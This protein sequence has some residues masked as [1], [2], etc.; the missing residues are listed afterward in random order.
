MN[1]LISF[2]SILLFTVS[3]S[4]ALSIDFV[5]Q[6]SDTKIK[7]IV[8]PILEQYCGS[9]C[10]ALQIKT[11]ID[12]DQPDTI[13]PG[14]DDKDPSDS[15]NLVA[16][17]A[18]VQL[19][20]DTRLGPKTQQKVISL[21]KNSL[22]ISL[23]YPVEVKSQSTEF[24]S[25]SSVAGKGVELREKLT[26]QF[27]STVE[28]VFSKFCGENCL[29]SEL[30]V[31]T[32]PVSL[33]ETQ[34]GA[35]NE[36]IH[37]G[38][39]ALKIKSIRGTLLMNDALSELD[40]SNIFEM[41]KLKTSGFKNVDLTTKSMKFPS[42]IKADAQD[43]RAI[44]SETH[45]T[46]RTIEKSSNNNSSQNTHQQQ[47]S[48]RSTA[49]ETSTTPSWPLIA[50]LLTLLM[51]G[52]IAAWFF[53]K[54]QTPPP[55]AHTAPVPS[56][57]V[58]HEQAPDAT[59]VQSEDIAQKNMKQKLELYK[60]HQELTQLMADQP[61]TSKQLFTSLIQEES[62]ELN[63]QVLEIFGDAYYLELMRPSTLE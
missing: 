2:I 17:S 56:T 6:Q 5:K 15:E 55:I 53:R 62:V 32:E 35:P 21:I 39:L 45:I 7:K 43:N 24:P 60:L 28:E 44:K 48:N 27:K 58:N 57:G 37:D 59:L 40:R 26:R 50:G 47:D 41:V 46:E 11:E 9:Q 18:T 61:K 36:F 10:K 25:A 13:N 8:E 42:L 3:N 38:E 19:L 54:K 14:F 23:D 29:L 12:T 33:E 22:D 49:S 1:K 30:D 4:H 16:G 63:A 20:F 51:G 31:S 52:M 34:Y